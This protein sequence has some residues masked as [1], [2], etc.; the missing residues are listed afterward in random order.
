MQIT[1]QKLS[2]KHESNLVKLSVSQ[3]LVKL[4]IITKKKKQNPAKKYNN[5]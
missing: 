2:K 1:K 4:V 3:A 5:L